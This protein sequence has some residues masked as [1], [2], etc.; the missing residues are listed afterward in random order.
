MR[1]AVL[2]RTVRKG[3]GGV[4]WS[5]TLE[6]LVSPPSF[7]DLTD[8]AGDGPRWLLQTGRGPEFTLERNE[9]ISPENIKGR[10]S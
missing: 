6:F 8:R 10:V 7:A 3:P 2:H 5:V 4:R 9:Q 1:A